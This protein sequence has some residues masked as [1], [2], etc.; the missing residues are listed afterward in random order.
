MKQCIEELPCS[1]GYMRRDSSKRVS[2]CFFD[3]VLMLGMSILLCSAGGLP[4]SSWAASPAAD[5]AGSALV[6]IE[7]QPAADARDVPVGQ[8]LTVHLNKRV[9]PATLN[10]QTVTLMGP[11]GAAAVKLVVADGGLAL[12][13]TP[14]QE[15]LPASRYTLFIQGASDEEGQKLPFTAI[16]FNTAALSAGGESAKHPRT[17]AQTLDSAEDDEEWIPNAGNRNGN[18]QSGRASLAEKNMPRRESLRRALYGRYDQPPVTNWATLKAALDAKAANSGPPPGK[19]MTALAGQVLRLNGRPLADV[20]VEMGSATTKTDGNGEFLLN[21]VPS[22]Y[23]QLLIVDGGSANRRDA[24]YGRFTFVTNVLPGQTNDLDFVVWMPKLD[25]RHAVTIASPTTR[26]TVI[27]NPNIPGVE[28]VLPPGAVIR[29]AH[30]RIATQVSITP[31][32][33]DQ[34]PFPM[35]YFDVPVYFT[36]QPGGAVIQGVDGKPKG[37]LLRY[38]NYSAF[39]PDH[40]VKLFD[41]DPNGRGWYSYGTGKVSDDGRKIVSGR[42]FTIYQFTANGASS[43]YTKPDVPLPK[44]PPPPECDVP[45]SSKSDSASQ[46]PGDASGSQSCNESDPGW[47]AFPDGGDPVNLATGVLKNVET[48][49]TVADVVPIALTRTYRTLDKSGGTDI[50]RPF[51]IASSHPYEMYLDMPAGFTQINLVL[52]DGTVIPFTSIALNPTSYHTDYRNTVTAGQ[53]YQSIIH[54]DAANNS[55]L[56]LYFRDGRRWGFFAHTARLQWIDD[57]NGNRVTVSRAGGLGT[58]SVTQIMGPSGRY[59]NLSYNANGQISQAKDHTG[60]TVTY[61]YDAGKRLTTVTDPT[62][63]VRTYVWDTGNNRISSIKDAKNTTTV[64]ITYDGNG[65]VSG[66]TLADSST[67]GFAY[68]LSS[69]VVTR[70]EVTDRRSNVRRVD[71]NSAG[72]ITANTFPLGLTEE[73]VTSFTLDST[74]GRVTSMT[75]ALS[76]RTDYTYDSLGN[77]T[78]LTRLAG[79]GDAVSSSATYDTTYSRP[80]T[81]TDANNKTTTLTYDASGNLTQLSDPLSHTSQMT[82]DGQGRV[83]TVIDGL[84]HTVATLTYSGPDLASV[85]DA[86]SRTTNFYTD[87]AG[88][89]TGIKDPLGRFTVKSYDVLNRL[90]QIT[91]ALNGTLQF[92]YDAN[93]N[94]LTHVDQNSHA[95]TYTYDAIDRLA[96]KVDALTHTESYAYE[97]SGKLNKIT[98][99]KSQVSGMTYDGVGRVTLKGYGATTGNPTLR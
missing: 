90:T 35:P 89:L 98:D 79:T 12:F 81:I 16:G 38:P 30:G 64:S 40:L 43:G 76:R 37:A 59:I 57:R 92:T 78:Q 46:N 23:N 96:T 33:V 13:I 8:Q 10:A 17:T 61:G 41:Y 39:G 22:G 66:E 28:L 82:Y 67:F 53:F 48:D 56:T 80:L 34:T 72:Q 3:L 24:T 4:Q 54:Y 51:G 26:E 11:S 27:S 63:G 60:R 5:S 85:T 93:S 2:V 31:I 15:L 62:S 70:T 87:G 65:R 58:G 88:R 74:T 1:S 18:W 84:S 44:A 14:F 77:V 45:S 32:P 29:D 7:S 71:F 20:T 36:L 49:M 99:R 83:L 50:L 6:V 21:D 52:P 9:D 55:Q 94:L 97:A 42:D 25:M 69:G 86:L 75:D 73:Q 91:N 19:G 68:T 95:T 47:Y